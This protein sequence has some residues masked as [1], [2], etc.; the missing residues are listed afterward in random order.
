MK[1]VINNER[2]GL[3]FLR[4]GYHAYWI[5]YSNGLQCLPNGKFKNLWCRP[6]FESCD[7]RKLKGVISNEFE[8]F[9]KESYVGGGI[10]EAD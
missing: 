1:L 3:V 6:K 4:G 7:I 10:K 5:R 2:M 9:C 8:R